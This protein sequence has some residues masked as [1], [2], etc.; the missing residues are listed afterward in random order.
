MSRMIKQIQI[1]TRRQ[2]KIVPEK[3]GWNEAGVR[4]IANYLYTQ[5]FEF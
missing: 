1:C 2:M 3:K 4:G 5:P